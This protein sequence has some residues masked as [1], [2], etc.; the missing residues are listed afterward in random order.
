M[1]E[2]KKKDSF[3]FSDK[4]KNS[5]PAAS[6]KSFANRISSKVGSDGKP[7]K[8]LFE[9]TKRDAPFFIAALVALLLLPFLYK[10]SGS[11]S[12]EPVITP[13]SEDSVFDPERYGFDTVTAGDPEGQIAALSGRDSLTLIKGWGKEEETVSNDYSS[14]LPEFSR[15]GFDE[16]DS[17]SS[18][19]DEVETNNTNIYKKAPA[20]TRAAFR[21]AATKINPLGSA[22]LNSRG[23][24][25]LAVGM[26]GGGMKKAANKVTGPASPT[27]SPKPVSL[28][29]LQAA[30]KPSRSYFGQG[31][32]KEARRSKDAMSKANAMQ[33]LA[34]A[35]V[36]AIEPGKIGGLMGGEGSG[37][38]GGAANLKRDFSYK[39]EKPWWWD[40]MKQRSQMLW[41]RDLKRKWAWEDW[42]DNLIR[43]ILGN[44]A[45][46]VANCLITG[47]D[48][49]SMGSM[50]GAVAGSGDPDKCGEY[51][52]EEW[53]KCSE[54]M[55]FGPFGKGSCKMFISQF[56]ENS[57]AAKKG[58]QDGN[59][60]GANMGF[61]GKR[62][63]CLSNGLGS[64]FSGAFRRDK[65]AF[66]EKGDCN[67]FAKEGIYTADFS[68][69]KGKESKWRVFHYVVGIPADQLDTYYRETLKKRREML[70]VGY[71]DEGAE[72]DRSAD[73]AK[74]RKNFVPLFIE[75]VAIK[76]KKV[77]NKKVDNEKKEKT[78]KKYVYNGYW[79]AATKK[80][81][82]FSED[83]Y[84]A[85]IKKC[86]SFKWKVTDW[87]CIKEINAQATD[88]DLG[89]KL[90]ISLE[91]G[92]T[93][94]SYDEFVELLRE[95]GVVQDAAK[96]EGSVG[97][98]SLAISTKH[99]KMG[100]SFITGARCSYPL[101]TI[102]CQNFA[103]VEKDGKKYPYAHVA[104]A[105]AMSK[106][107]KNYL[108]M[109]DKF[110]IT[111]HVQGEDNSFAGAYTT[112][113]SDKQGQVFPVPHT[114]LKPFERAFSG[115][116]KA[117]MKSN[118]VGK[119]SSE[120]YNGYQALATSDIVTNMLSEAGNKDDKRLVI[121]WEIRQ[122]RDVVASGDNIN[123]GGCSFGTLV[124][125]DNKPIGTQLPGTV[126]SS[127]Y[128]VYDDDSEHIVGFED[129]IGS[130][131]VVVT[132]TPAPKSGEPKEIGLSGTVKG[133]SGKY[134][135]R[136]GLKFPTLLNDF[137]TCTDLDDDISN[138][139]VY[140]SSA[141]SEYV[142]SVITDVNA[143]TN[144]QLEKNPERIV[145]NH[146][147]KSSVAHL[148]D[149]MT[150]AH[151]LN[152]KAMVS[153]NVVC[154]LGKTIGGIAQD[155]DVQ[156][157][158]NNMFGAFAA[159]IDEES[160]FFP[161]RLNADGDKDWRFIGCRDN[162]PTQKPQIHYGYYNWNQKKFGDLGYGNEGRDGFLKSLRDGGWDRFPLRD[163]A[164]KLDKNV[165]QKEI[166][167]VNGTI[168]DVVR[169]RYIYQYRSVFDISQDKCDY[170]GDMKVEDALEYVNLVCKNGS[171]AKPKNGA[172]D[173]N[174]NRFKASTVTGN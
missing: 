117:E 147:S 49:G 135:E 91:N 140:D 118:N 111:Y 7:R 159:Y 114:A 94:P 167:E 124:N 120:A 123:N 80:E 84:E 129:K 76:G 69:A 77:D 67:V 110:L 58:W 64:R 57:A 4:I 28:Q 40:M 59:V 78:P 74:L 90:T 95:G 134:E 22:G 19:Y 62:L 121:N 172:T 53:E 158:V 45:T 108:S 31:A 142:D 41:E 107:N 105:N 3:T 51:T 106:D 112:D 122:C 174:R 171:R 87:D 75:S 27:N 102:S 99:S 36:R 55:Q 130:N 17:R 92:K 35:Q 139:E 157:P 143:S 141:V 138:R 109:Q 165:T 34:D 38:G 52:K 163:L 82:T 50:F 93:L 44:I 23:G 24:G 160:S 73:E 30:G 21:R 96:A 12:E 18:S 42:G 2:E 20:A 133:I 100:K 156:N 168:D 15:D 54:C 146:T 97:K 137:N 81:F 164:K 166:Q 116:P 169:K 63:D 89:K 56:G 16:R 37:P 70:V 26:W 14:S 162:I 5:K 13:A 127:A 60:A 85:A 66:A 136:L 152:P 47:E 161:T 132:K 43:S 48:D 29:P 98:D 25:K 88:E 6:S 173:C 101:A 155:P 32:A 125:D 145:L 8:T 103:F 11:V 39:G 9:R 126:V 153:K 150:L 170:T 10:Y 128:C 65:G 72:F 115:K 119:P 149:A 71:F 83:S 104:F 79:G 148:V 144:F 131:P 154:A 33:A 68:T 151:S 113:A 61:F 46:G 1:P 86:K